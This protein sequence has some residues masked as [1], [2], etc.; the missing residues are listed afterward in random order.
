MIQNHKN[1]EEIFEHIESSFSLSNKRHPQSNEGEWWSSSNGKPQS[2]LAPPPPSI[3]RSS[4]SPHSSNEESKVEVNYK[5]KEEEEVI[6]VEMGDNLKTETEVTFTQKIFS[7]SKKYC[8]KQYPGK[9]QRRFVSLTWCLPTVRMELGNWR[10][11]SRRKNSNK[12]R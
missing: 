3:L 4:S 7:D 6:V 11:R 9:T 12:M 8:I 5:A 10:W 1:L 2:S